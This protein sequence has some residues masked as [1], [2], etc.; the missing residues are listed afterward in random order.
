MSFD[1]YDPYA[2][3]YVKDGPTKTKLDWG[4]IFGFFLC[5]FI[6]FS[7]CFAFYMAGKADNTKRAEWDSWCLA[8]PGARIEDDPSRLP[9]T[10][11]SYN[12]ACVQNGTIIGT[13]A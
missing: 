5:G 2:Q 12:F 1:T 3:S 4:L 10:A 7:F 13:R 11:V 8:Q 6:F 9:P